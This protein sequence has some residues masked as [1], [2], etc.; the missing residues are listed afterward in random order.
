MEKEL[1]HLPC[2]A[3]TGLAVKFIEPGSTPD[4]IKS[5]V[6]G[7]VTDETK[8]AVIGYSLLK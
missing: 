2:G 4:V 5:V 7:W 8:C 3:V 1:E 6:I